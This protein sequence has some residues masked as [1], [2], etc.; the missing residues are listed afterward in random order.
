MVF[1][2][3]NYLGDHAK[4]GQRVQGCDVIVPSVGISN[5]ARY[6]RVGGKHGGVS[7]TM[8]GA[9]K[10]NRYKNEEVPNPIPDDKTIELT[11]TIRL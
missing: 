1:P 9:L 8:D 11:W 5:D 3:V 4:G 2:E 7:V 10:S 6:L